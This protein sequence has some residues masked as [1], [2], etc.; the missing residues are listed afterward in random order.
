[1]IIAG[2]CSMRALLLLGEECVGGNTTRPYS[3]AAVASG[4][5]RCEFVAAVLA[6]LLLAPSG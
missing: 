4:H 3:S 2:A 5:A 1:M 6:Q